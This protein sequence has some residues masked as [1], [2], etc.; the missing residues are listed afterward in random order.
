MYSA[1]PV[2]VRKFLAFALLALSVIPTAKGQTDTRAGRPDLLTVVNSHETDIPIE[3]ARVLLLTTCRVVAEQFNKKPDDLELR[4]TLIFGEPHE[5]VAVD[6]SGGMTLYLEH[7][8][9]TKFVDGVITGAMQLLM[10]L[11]TRKQVF[12]E[13]LR[14]TE[15]IA[16]VAAN[17]LRIPGTNSPVPI[18]SLR[19]DCISVVNNAPCSWPNQLPDR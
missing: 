2:G 18:R 11:H 5:R 16:P 12:T 14:R 1:E 3:R 10:P 9:E 7:W 13:I 6:D 19:P 15:K 17:K 8:N 4:M